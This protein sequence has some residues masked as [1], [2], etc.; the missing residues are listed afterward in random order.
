[1]RDELKNSEND[2]NFLLNQ[3]ND[4]VAF[5]TKE[6]EEKSNEILNLNSRISAFNAS[7]QFCQDKF[8]KTL[9]EQEILYEEKLQTFCNLNLQLGKNLN[10]SFEAFSKQNSRQNVFSIY[11]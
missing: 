9:K 11:A 7:K 4:V 8:E 10:I 5:L 2:K 3:K 1:M 6:L